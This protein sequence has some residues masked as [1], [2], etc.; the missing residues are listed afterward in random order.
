MDGQTFE[1][2]TDGPKAIVVGV[3]GTPSSLRALAFASGLAR[4]QHAELICAYVRRPAAVPAGVF[5][6]TP[7]EA[8]VAIC[9][10]ETEFGERLSRRVTDDCGTWGT[11]ARVV[12][13]EGDPLT[14]LAAVADQVHADMIVVGA[15]TGL[16]HRLFGS[17]ASRLLRRRRWP[18]T[19]VP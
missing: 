12:V 6:F 18:I 5:G 15:S 14:E 7:A 8:T 16:G 9:E 13:R 3:D 4:R 17:L 1:L 2:G 19:V 10:A 11:G